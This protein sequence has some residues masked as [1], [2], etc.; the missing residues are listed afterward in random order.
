M[1]A[2]ASHP[3]HCFKWKYQNNSLGV[4]LLLLFNF[5]QEVCPF[6]RSTLAISILSFT[7]PILS[8]SPHQ[9]NEQTK[10]VIITY[11]CITGDL[12]QQQ[13]QQQWKKRNS[14]SVHAASFYSKAC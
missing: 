3:M 9:E 2:Q 7:L 4:F 5:P 12:K 6:M 11:M 1:K 8:Q 14:C 10:P 13:Q